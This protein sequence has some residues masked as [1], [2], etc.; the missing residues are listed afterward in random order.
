M[1]VPVPQAKEVTVPLSNKIAKSSHDLLLETVKE[2]G[3]TIKQVLEFGI[4]LAS[5]NLRKGKKK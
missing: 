5:E 3:L 2:N 1:T 4:K